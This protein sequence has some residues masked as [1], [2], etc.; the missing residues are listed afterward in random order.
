MS[1]AVFDQEAFYPFRALIHG[2][3]TGAEQLRQIE[4]FLRAIVLHDEM[5][6]VGEP[7]TRI[8]GDDDE[9]TEEEVRAGGRNVIVGFAPILDGYKGVLNNERRITDEAV[10]PST[11]LSE[12]AREFSGAGPEDPYY[13]AHLGYLR[14]L[15]GVLKDGGSVVCEGVVGKEAFEERANP[16]DVVFET[17]DRGW[18]EYAHSARDGFGFVLP[19]VLAI[20]LTRAARRE[21]LLGIIRDLRD[22][23]SEPRR[24]LWELIAAARN[25]PTMREAHDAQREL[26]EAQRLFDPTQREPSFAPIRLIWD[27]F[28]TGV[29]TAAT[30]G[31]AGVP[32][33]AA[34]AAGVVAAGGIAIQKVTQEAPEA[35]RYWLRQGA[36]DLARRVRQELLQVEAIPVL[37]ARHLRDDEKRQLGL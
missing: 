2:G 34:L 11:R 37:L 1:K 35:G 24:R 31:M 25:A 23:W 16:P 15:T 19:P 28:A 33:A 22:E 12:L 4:R 10:D 5:S 32:P 13:R 29:A 21:N 9:W 8:A 7:M 17:L 14:V 36:F 18:A 26:A 6:M 20:A 27:V 30:T 3:V